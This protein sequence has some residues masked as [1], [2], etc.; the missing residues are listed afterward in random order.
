[1]VETAILKERV[2][3]REKSAKAEDAANKEKLA[4]ETK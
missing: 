2:R 4:G 1:M 3:V